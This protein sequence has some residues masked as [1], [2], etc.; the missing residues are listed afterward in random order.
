MGRN[1]CAVC[2]LQA[3]DPDRKTAVEDALVK[4]P[5]RAAAKR[6]SI[7]PT[8]AWRHI[9]HTPDLAG[10]RHEYVRDHHAGDRR[11]NPEA[12]SEAVPA[13]PPAPPLDRSASPPTS[14]RNVKGRRK[15]Q[16]DS[17]TREQVHAAQVEP[18]SEG[19]G[20]TITIPA[21]V[22]KRTGEIS[23]FSPLALLA[24]PTVREEEAWQLRIGGKSYMA[25]AERLQLFL[26]DGVTPDWKGAERLCVMAASRRPFVLELA[27]Q[28]ELSRLDAIIDTLWRRAMTAEV[29]V[30]HNGNRTTLVAMTEEQDRAIALLLQAQDR[31]RK[32]G[33][34]EVARS[35]PGAVGMLGSGAAIGSLPPALARLDPPPTPAELEHYAKTGQVPRRGLHANEPSYMVV[36][37]PEEPQI[38][39]AFGALGEDP[40]DEDDRGEMSDPP[41]PAPLPVDPVA[42]PAPEPLPAASTAPATLHAPPRPPA[43]VAPAQA[44]PVVPPRPVAPAPAALQ[45]EAPTPPVAQPAAPPAPARQ[46]QL[47]FALRWKAAAPPAPKSVT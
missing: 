6:F 39:T 23:P 13:S 20:V 1:V 34:L 4:L 46:G 40:D 30:V 32:L 22:D 26:A 7:A 17:R 19:G 44:A 35:A 42:Q 43:P 25:I 11:I 9:Q 2:A 12:R 28:E 41:E 45:P 18:V 3:T 37:P 29:E 10:K 21:K 5:H 14:V 8:A 47:P 31:R 36:Q 16:G 33:G 24:S 15:R 27:R 38:P